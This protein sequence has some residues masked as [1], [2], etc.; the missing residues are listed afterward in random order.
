MSNQDELDLAKC[1]WL[2]ARNGGVGSCYC[3]MHVVMNRVKSPD[4]PNTIH[5]VIYGKNQFSWTRPDDPQYGLEPSGL[6]YDACLQIAPFVIAGDSDPTNGS[7]Y[8]SNEK[9]ITPGGWYEKNIIKNPAHPILIVIG[10]HT[11]RA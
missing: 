5:A 4:F 10:S 1:G 11:F 8:Y 3:V 9:Y 2:E 7:L 6:I